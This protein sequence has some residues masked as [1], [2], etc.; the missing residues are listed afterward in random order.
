MLTQEFSEHFCPI[1]VKNYTPYL[2]IKGLIENK[3]IIK[4]DISIHSVLDMQGA[5]K[6]YILWLTSEANI[7]WNHLLMY[8]LTTWVW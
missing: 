8:L 2:E 7:Q 3:V 1:F 6:K 5:S 4:L